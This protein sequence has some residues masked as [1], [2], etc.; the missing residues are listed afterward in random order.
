MNRYTKSTILKTVISKLLLEPSINKETNWMYYIYLPSFPFKI[1]TLECKL[2]T[3]LLQNKKNKK[4]ENERGYESQQKN[5]SFLK[6]LTK[7]PLH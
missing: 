7:I 6:L 3:L 1:L 5:C 2:I 4:R